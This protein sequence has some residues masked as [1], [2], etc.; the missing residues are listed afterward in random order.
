MNDELIV[1]LRE[2]LASEEDCGAAAHAAAEALKAAGASA[3]ITADDGAAEALSGDDGP[4]WV[5]SEHRL[6]IDDE[7][8]AEW[9]RCSAG[10]YG[11]AGRQCSEDEWCVSEDT[12]GGD[13]LPETVAAVLKVFGLED[14]IPDVPE[15]AKADEEH[16]EC[17]TGEYAV[18]WETVGDDA[19]VVARYATREA[20]EA[21]CAQ[22]NREFA[23]SNPSGGGTTYLCGYG[24]RERVGGKWVAD[25]AEDY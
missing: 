15:P 4:L 2:L 3:E 6:V 23:A 1:G 5:V 25:S 21:V 9:T 19:H 7:T 8:V 14:D 16:E 17:P 22:R 18:Y 11:E 24:V 13:G 20:A 12:E 10:D